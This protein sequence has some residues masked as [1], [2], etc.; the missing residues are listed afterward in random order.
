MSENILEEYVARCA[1]LTEENIKLRQKLS[2]AQSK[3]AWLFVS[4][5]ELVMGEPVKDGAGNH[6]EISELESPV[7]LTPFVKMFSKEIGLGEHKQAE[8]MRE[9]VSL[10]LAHEKVGLEI[11]HGEC[12]RLFQESGAENFLIN[13]YGCDDGEEYEITVQRLKGES[14]AEQVI[15]LQKRI[16]ELEGSVKS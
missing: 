16:A 5:L 2:E 7:E 9:L 4:F 3:G 12:I 1:A 15:R 6:P 8:I 13:H 11:V 14:V 10:S